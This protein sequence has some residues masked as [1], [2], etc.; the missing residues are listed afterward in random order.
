MLTG[1]VVLVVKQKPSA[2]PNLVE[3]TFLPVPVSW[4]ALVNNC[5]ETRVL[6]YGGMVCRLPCRVC[7]CM[8]V[9]VR[10]RVCACVYVRVCEC[11]CVCV[12]VCLSVCVCVFVNVYNMY[13]FLCQCVRQTERERETQANDH[14]PLLSHLWP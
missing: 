10:V 5:D 8:C 12:C 3:R 1:D 13:V 4:A 6:I 7:V 14:I 2:Y 11:V 9:C